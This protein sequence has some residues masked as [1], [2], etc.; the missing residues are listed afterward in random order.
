MPLSLSLSISLSLYTVFFL[1]SLTFSYVFHL[2]RR[3]CRCRCCCCCVLLVRLVF[4]PHPSLSCSA[5]CPPLLLLASS[6][7][8]FASVSPLSSILS[9]LVVFSFCFHTRVSYH[10]SCTH[11]HRR[12]QPPFVAALCGVWNCDVAAL[13]TKIK[14]FSVEK[15]LKRRKTL[16]KIRKGEKSYKFLGWFLNFKVLLT[17]TVKFLVFWEFVKFSAFP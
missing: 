2:A 17:E 1:F 12:T 13:H 7:P 10:F 15:K 11:T 6:P 3:V 14:L 8:L 9:P 4:T 16:W 5:P